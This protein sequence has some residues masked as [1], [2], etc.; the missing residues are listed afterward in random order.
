MKK[1]TLIY[2]KKNAFS[3]FYCNQLIDFFEHQEVGTGIQS[4]FYG[5][6]VDRKIKN[7]LDL[8]IKI[9]SDENPLIVTL[10]KI[11]GKII[12]VFVKRYPYVD[13]LKYWE[14]YPGA[15][16]QKYPPM[17]GYLVDHCE[18]AVEEEPSNK[19][20]LAW[21]V[22]LNDVTDK[23]G[24]HFAHQNITLKAR[25]GDLY[26]WPA[27][28]THIHRGIPSPSQIKYIVTGWCNHI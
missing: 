28:F 26:I 4:D 1:S 15:N 8:G 6:R 27:Y 18:Y 22:Y 10:R 3:K 24:T 7:S 14:V 2:Q 19:R 5:K 17:G 20:I 13:G 9:Y 21:M 11:L 16:I 25:A 23:G 12:R